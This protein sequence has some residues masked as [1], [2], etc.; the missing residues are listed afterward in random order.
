MRFLHTADWQIGMHA[1]H[2]GAGAETVRQQRLLT[3]REV[4]AVATR[5]GAEFIVVAG[6]LFQDNGVERVLVQQTADILGSFAGPVYVIPGNHDPLVPGCV[7][8]HPAWPAHA[9]ITILT[10]SAMVV[11]AWGDL[12]PC[13]VRAKHSSADPTAWLTPGGRDRIRVGIAHGTVQGVPVDE[14]DYPIARD[15]A[16]RA[17]LDYLALGHWH[18]VATYPNRSG[19]A[20]MAYSGTHE[21]SR[22]GERDSGNVL[23]VELTAPGAAPVITPIPVGGLT[24]E[25]WNETIAVPGDLRR[26][27]ERIEALGEPR[28]RLMALQLDGIFGAAEAG[29]L[30]RI[31]QLLAARFLSWRIDATG[32]RPLPEDDAW[33]ADLPIGPVRVAA[34]KLRELAN[35]GTPALGIE[36]SPGAVAAQALLTLHRLAHT[37]NS[38]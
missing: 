9:N 27:R 33:I 29:E 15:A 4:I 7:W 28:R 19:T 14:P 25:S 1:A 38:Q 11:R 8:E 37:R 34:A 24:W 20:H 22:F 5:E 30:D 31:N 2:A 13:P 21:T 6:D 3:A 26:V 32:L 16:E 12:F 17:G 18:S 23:L 35:A 10:D 36:S